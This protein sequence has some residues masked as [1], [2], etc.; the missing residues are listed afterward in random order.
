MASTLTWSS[1]DTSTVSPLPAPRVMI[2]SAELASTGSRPGTPMSTSDSSSPAASLM[3][4]AGR[5]WRPTAEPTTTDLVGMGSPS[6]GCLLR[7]LRCCSDVAT[8][9]HRRHE[10]REEDASWCH[11]HPSRHSDH[12]SGRRRWST[13]ISFLRSWELEAGHVDEL[14]AHLSGG[15][16]RGAR[17]RGCRA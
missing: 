17:K 15:R 14:W 12:G 11:D 6:A 10:L 7:M 16:D 3:I 13:D 1:P 8:S 4:A 2:S 5:A 9:D